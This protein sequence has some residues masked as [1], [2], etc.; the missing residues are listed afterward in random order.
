MVKIKDSSSDHAAT[1]LVRCSHAFAQH[2]W[3]DIKYYN[4]RHQRWRKV[5]L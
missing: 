2:V 5:L 1:H 3:R 4:Y